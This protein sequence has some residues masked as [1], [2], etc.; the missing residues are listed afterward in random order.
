MIENRI[1]EG[2]DCLQAALRIGMTSLWVMVGCKICGLGE[3]LNSEIAVSHTL[4]KLSNIQSDNTR[5]ETILCTP[6]TTIHID[7]PDSSLLPLMFVK[8]LIF[9][10]CCPV[11][12]IGSCSR[13]IMSCTHCISSTYWVSL[14]QT[15][16]SY[17][18]GSLN[19]ITAM[20][21][22]GS[23]CRQVVN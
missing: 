5:L 21:L 17:D 23:G 8:S 4:A 11:I 20:D 18:S 12:N 6:L 19:N 1:C 3:Q 2:T 16:Y 7:L 9:L 10:S 22:C 13:V 15:S 14:L